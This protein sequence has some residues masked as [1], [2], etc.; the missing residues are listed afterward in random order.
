[1]DSAFGVDLYQGID[2]QYLF[3]AKGNIKLS[4]SRY[5]KAE[6]NAL[7]KVSIATYNKVKLYHLINNLP[8]GIGKSMKDLIPARIETPAKTFIEDVK[9]SLVKEI[10]GLNKV[11]EKT[12]KEEH[13]QALQ[14]IL[15]LYNS[16]IKGNNNLRN[17]RQILFRSIENHYNK[18]VKSASYL[19]DENN[20][21]WSIR[22]W[23][24]VVTQAAGLNQATSLADLTGHLSTSDF[25]ANSRLINRAFDTETSSR[26]SNRDGDNVLFELV[27]ISGY[28]TKPEGKK[29]INL[30]PDDKLIQD[31]TAFI[32]DGIVENLRYGAKSTSLGLRTNGSRADRLFLIVVSSPITKRL[33][34]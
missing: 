31:L 22:E 3:D 28:S 2:P 5:T 27:N 19:N 6:R 34:E 32:K 9:A 10:E 30:D 18:V 17:E 14:E 21:E 8:K 23:Q 4:N 29:T 11:I 16:L 25:V 13:K 12:T 33:V 1:M 20:L 15:D 26:I 24:H 7:N